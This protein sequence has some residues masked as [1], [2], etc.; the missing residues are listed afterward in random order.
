V[1]DVSLIVDLVLALGA[2]T[3][4][5]IIAQ[6]LGLPALIG[7]ILAGLAI[8]PN[9]PGFVADQD[10]VALL[11]NLGVALLMFGLGVEFSL[12]EVRRVRRAALL[13]GALQIPLTILLGTAAGL[14]FGW[15]LPAALLLGGAFAISSS[16]VALKTLLGRGEGESPQARVALGL[17]IVQ[18]LSLAPML[19]LVPVLANLGGGL[20]MGLAQ[21]LF[22]SGAALVLAYVLGTRLVPP[23][24]RSVAAVGSR[25]LFLLTVVAVA[26]GVAL[27]TSAAGLSLGL[28]AF[29]AGIV[30]S[31]SEFEEQV[32]AD[33]IPV[34]DLFATLFFVAVGMLI[35]PQLLA[36]NWQKVLVLAAVLVAGKLLITG[37]AL[38]AAGVDHRTATLA[39]VVLAQMG[40][41][42]F[43]LAGSGLAEGLIDA[44]QYGLIL[45]VALL[46][47]LAMPA[48]VGLSPWLIRLAERL[49]GVAWQ[50]RLAAGPPLPPA[51]A[52]GHV[53]LCGFGRVGAEIGAAL[54]RWGEPY[55]VI[56][57]NPA[58]V[59]DL[60]ERGI[61]AL[62][63]DAA[64]RVE[65]EQAGLAR[66]VT[67]AV[68]TP[69]LLTTEAVLRHAR[70]I[71]PDIRIIVRAP[72]ALDAQ[73][74]AAGGADII[75]QPEFEAGLE[76]VRQVLGWQG[77]GQTYTDDLVA[78]RR[79]EVYAGEIQNAPA[80]VDQHR[81]R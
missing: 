55:S 77:I 32:L 1:E 2:A 28:G 57:L 14:A 70:E 41:F 5:G 69:D 61:E 79:R 76:F 44:D 15:D 71:N 36:A 49:P 51:P 67:V 35:D 43:V 3:V 63:G 74:L 48:L 73:T 56:E 68:T 29:L 13:G 30:V 23:L 18:D 40:E 11:A 60:R 58:I 62:Y 78:A 75:V 22:L 52:G 64:S 50:E 12:S 4:G 72:A 65:L 39:A 10:R 37:G 81:S 20:G 33:I 7:Y 9:T 27:T 8:G 59:R 46:S 38:L 66:A 21:S 80:D 34:R 24:L 54:D 19:A 17:S 31:E 42:S 16:I 6:R 26:L 25:E 47:I 53:V 45:S